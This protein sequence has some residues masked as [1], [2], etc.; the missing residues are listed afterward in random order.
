[1]SRNELRK[2]SDILHKSRLI[3][4]SYIKLLWKNRLLKRYNECIPIFTLRSRTLAADNNLLEEFKE[5][6]ENV[7]LE[8]LKEAQMK[9]VAKDVVTRS[10]KAEIADALEVISGEIERVKG[11]LQG[12]DYISEEEIKA[13]VQGAYEK[14]GEDIKESEERLKGVI[15][16]RTQELYIANE[17]L[18]SDIETVGEQVGV[19]LNNQTSLIKQSV[20]EVGAIHRD[21]KEGLVKNETGLK[22]EIK[23]LF[24]I[25]YGLIAAV[26]VLS[27]FI[28]IRGF[29]GA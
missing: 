11:E 1:M 16:Q 15:E 10:Y 24:M 7:S 3:R 19:K 9:E 28:L 2:E 12:L 20:N 22:E 6:I 21:I 18:R 25:N 26:I 29:Y 27:I 8:I 5:L 17:K 13:V 23:K 14:Q 4:K